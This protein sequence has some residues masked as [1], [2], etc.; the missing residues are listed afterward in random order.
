MVFAVVEEEQVM[1]LAPE[2]ELF[3]AYW[4]WYPVMFEMADQ[5]K[6]KAFALEVQELIFT[7]A[8]IALQETAEDV[9][10]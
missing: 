8:G 3:V 1:V 4:I 2:N 10:E 9:L 5:F 6:V 7:L